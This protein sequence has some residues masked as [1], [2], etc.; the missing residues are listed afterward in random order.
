M[1]IEDAALVGCSPGDG[2]DFGWS[3]VR[4]R[5]LGPR[6]ESSAPAVGSTRA[7]EAEQPTFALY[8]GAV[9]A[10]P[11]SELLPFPA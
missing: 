10:W 2:C 11:H 6:E 9:T 8:A 1:T 3:G 4:V 5:V 7:R